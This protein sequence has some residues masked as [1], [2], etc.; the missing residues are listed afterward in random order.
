MGR[1]G[2]VYWVRRLEGVTKRKS[3]DRKGPEI[4]VVFEVDYANLLNVL[5]SFNVYYYAEE[6]FD[7]RELDCNSLISQNIEFY[8]QFSWNLFLGKKH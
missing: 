7:W 6:V 3:P 5:G 2:L 1:T 8:F 4:L